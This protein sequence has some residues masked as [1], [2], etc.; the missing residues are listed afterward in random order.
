M[1]L[2][3][4]RHAGEFILS[5]ANGN[6]SRDNVII[7]SGENLVAGTVLGKITASGKYAA[8][9]NEAGTGIQT[10]A[11]ILMEA[12]D[13]SGG[14]VVAA[15]I[16]RDAEVIADALTYAVGNSGGDETAAIAD[17]KSLGIIV[18]S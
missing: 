5:E 6:R 16:V 10:A 1:A 13:A 11:G 17:L 15:A 7:V 14:D 9:D 2:T 3:E 12:T 4:G 8:Y 18:R